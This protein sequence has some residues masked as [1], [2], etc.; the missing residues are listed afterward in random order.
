M[1]RSDI[2]S[3]NETQ[4]KADL[5][6]KLPC[7]TYV[8]MK[9][10]VKILVV[11]LICVLISCTNTQNE[12][13]PIITVDIDKNIDN[14]EVVNLSEL[15]S[16]VK[17]I[18]LEKTD[19]FQ[20]SNVSSIDVSSEYFLISDR[21]N[22]LLF[23]SDGKFLS[24]IGNRGNGPDEYQ[25]IG[26]IAL[27]SGVS[28]SAFIHSLY[29]LIEYNL[30]GTFGKRYNGLLI[31]DEKAFDLWHLLNDSLVFINIPNSTG[32]EQNKA[33]IMNLHGEVVVQYGNY[34]TFQFINPRG[35]FIS[36]FAHIYEFNGSLWFKQ[37]FNDTLFYHDN[38]LKLNPKYIFKADNLKIP[39]SERLKYPIADILW[40]HK[41]LFEVY[42]TENYLF[43]KFL[44][45]NN[46]PA[47]RLHPKP[48]PFPGQSEIWI[49]TNYI[50]GIYDKKSGDLKLCKPTSTDN[51]LFTSGIYN[52]IDCGP[53]FFP[54]AV[55]ND[56][57]LLMSIDP[58][59]L[60]DHVKSEDFKS[61]PARFP[62]KKKELEDL[63]NELDLMDNPVLMLVTFK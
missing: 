34:E 52:D 19:N 10:V 36:E 48:S 8:E 49:N 31:N 4:I 46:F 32:M 5:M 1:T 53:R 33:I 18:P 11:S 23:N 6:Y 54:S 16:D 60:K 29:D 45:G 37:Y 51:P 17:Y 2:T 62:E 28:Q 55:V 47:K 40:S 56:S 61:N 15:A 7:L 35:N 27:G 42:Q 57:T 9:T 41:S 13:D 30:D 38:N 50:L 20:L 14:L 58:F 25:F 39:V 12:V 21:K 24:K 22:C 63:T 3:A 59:E 43:L 26:S 44:F